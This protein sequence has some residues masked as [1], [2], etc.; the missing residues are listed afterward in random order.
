[1]D[2]EQKE[3]E[4][5]QKQIVVKSLLHIEQGETISYVGREEFI[6]VL[7]KIIK[8]YQGHKFT[9]PTLPSLEELYTKFKG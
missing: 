5:F 4:F 2:W 8:L 1:M 9:N 3:S 7:V 6:D